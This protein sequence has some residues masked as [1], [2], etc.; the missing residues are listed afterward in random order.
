MSRRRSSISRIALGMYLV[1][2]LALTL[3]LPKSV[4]A[5]VQTTTS[6]SGIV[7]DSSGAVISGASVTVK[8]QGTGATQG[9]TTNATGFYSFP[10]LAPGTYTIMVGH[11][12][13]QMSEV[14][15]RV[16]DVAQP[17]SVDV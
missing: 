8:N 3:T 4:Q 14:K 16:L 1:T 13:F 2:F 7:T 17:A 5:Q 11:P 9:V 6:I 15:D 10:S 12:G